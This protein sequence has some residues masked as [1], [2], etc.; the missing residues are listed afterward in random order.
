RLDHLLSRETCRHPHMRPGNGPRGSWRRILGRPSRVLKVTCA[1]LLSFLELGAGNELG[2]SSDR[3][4]FVPLESQPA[5]RSTFDRKR[6][7]E[8]PSRLNLL[9][10]RAEVWACSSVG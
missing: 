6:T 3:A 7:D 8:S 5:F 1:I 10:C 4:R 9:C 2:R